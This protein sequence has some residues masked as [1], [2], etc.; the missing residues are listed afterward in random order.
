MN[1]V[2]IDDEP[3]IR[4]GLKKMLNNHGGWNVPGIFSNGEEAIEFLSKNEVDVVITDIHMPGI[5]GLDMIEKLKEANRKSV[6]I[7]LSGYGRF[8]YAKRAIDLGVKKFLTKPTSP[9]EII[10]TLEIIER[11]CQGNKE[12]KAQKIP[13]KNLMV[14]RAKEYIDINY[15]NKI[16][17]QDIADELYVS[18]NYIS[19][20]FKKHMGKK[21]S[22]YI[23]EVRMEKAK[24][25]LKDIRYNVSEVAEYVGFSDSRYFSNTFKKM[26]NIS[27][28]EYRK[29]YAEG[30]ICEK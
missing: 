25:C 22:E 24:E 12:T 23:I 3:K 8:E 6:F 19:E 28:T 26:F 16:T 7:I 29:M 10:E 4:N 1:I 2:I 30:K 5:T 15:Q 11:E 27:P 21:F 9:S 20:Q 17:L 14:L 18:P 13:V